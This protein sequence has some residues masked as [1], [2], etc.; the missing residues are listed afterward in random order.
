MSKLIY[1]SAL[2][3]VP[4]WVFKDLDKLVFDFLW[5]GKDKIKRNV[6]FLDYCRGGL[7]LTDFHL[8]IFVQRIMW[9][10]RLLTGDANMGWKQYFNYLTKDVGG[11]LMFYNNATVGI[12]ELVLPAFYRELLDVW[13]APRIFL[14]K[15]NVSKRNEIIYLF[16]S[17]NR[18]SCSFR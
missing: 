17:F 16:I 5:K 2:T 18:W 4:N 15:E 13:M 14:L 11:I 8:F 3:P 1:V 10:K 7:R 9:V 12:S 6:M